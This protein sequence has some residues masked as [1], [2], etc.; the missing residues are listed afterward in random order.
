M[1]K[2]S[3]IGSLFS[4]CYFF[5]NCSNLIEDTPLNDFK[6]HREY[7][8]NRAEKSSEDFQ[9]YKKLYE[10]VDT[11]KDSPYIYYYLSRLEEGDFYLNEGLKKFPSDPYINFNRKKHINNSNDIDKYRLYKDILNNFPR[12]ELS[13]LNLFLITSKFFAEPSKLFKG[14]TQRDVILDLKDIIENFKLKKNIESKYYDF[15]DKKNGLF[16]EDRIDYLTSNFLKYFDLLQN[17][18]KEI[19]EENK[20]FKQLFVG[21]KLY[22]VSN[23]SACNEWIEFYEDKSFDLIYTC[24]GVSSNETY[25]FKGIL[26]EKSNEIIWKTNPEFKCRLNRSREYFGN[27]YILDLENG[28]FSIDLFQNS[29]SGDKFYTHPFTKKSYYGFTSYQLEYGTPYN[30]CTR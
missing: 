22:V 18:L 15:N 3:K 30:G 27:K 7:L 21:K 26:N 1:R 28:K 11:I 6:T 4:I 13:L 2:L 24:Y 5:I 17:T 23:I 16:R 19:D 10:E 29:V 9:S 20:K 12:H 8:E 25:K 14:A